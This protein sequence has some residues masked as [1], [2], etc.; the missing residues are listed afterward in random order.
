MEPASDREDVAAHA[1]AASREGLLAHTL[2]HAETVL[3]SLADGVVVKDTHNKIVWANEAAAAIFGLQTKQML[4][5]CAADPIFDARHPDGTPVAPEALPSSRSLVTG[6]ATLGVILDLARP[7]GRRVWVEMSSKPLLQDGGSVYGA[8]TVVRDVTERMA[9]TEALRFHAALLDAVGQAVVATDAEGRITY[10]N[11]A[12]VDM[13]GWTA[14]EA[15][16][17]L[18]SSLGADPTSD[19]DVA[20]SDALHAGRSW[21]GELLVRD[22]DGRVFPAM[23]TSRPLLD[24]DGTVRG[25]IGVGIDVSEQHAMQDAI[26]HQAA[27]DS[28]TGLPNRAALD[29]RL[30]EALAR[31]AETGR[32]VGVLFIDLDFFKSINDAVGHRAGD[33]VLRHVARRL[34]AAVGGDHFVAR[35]GGDEFVAIVEEADGTVA[36]QVAERVTEAL[37]EPVTSGGRLHYVTSSIGV[38]LSPPSDPEELLALADA[39][40]HGAKSRGRDRV[41]SPDGRLLQETRERVD[42]AAKLREAIDSELLA[43]HYQ[44][45][46]E[47]ASGEVVGVEALCRWTDPELGPISPD[48]F[49]AVAESTGLVGALDRWVLRRAAMDAR[50]LVDRGLLGPQGKVAVNLSAHN[51]VEAGLEAL[52]HQ[53]VEEAGI[54][55]P[56][57]ALEITETGVMSDPELAAAVLGRL[58]EHGI[59]VHVDDFGTGYSSLS[60]LRRLPISV[61]K[62]D[63]TFIKDLATEPDDLAITVSII[64]LSR[65]LGIR[66]IAEGVETPQQLAL[67]KQRGCWAGQGYLWSPPLPL[68][69]LIELL[70]RPDR[71]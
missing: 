60:Y 30:N 2:A 39:A 58:R 48:R 5:A 22:R 17:R 29:E 12:A 27:H 23:V 34:A 14:E 37:R 66:T 63:R 68:P 9:R 3:S 8:V 70:E 57:L 16:G 67:L 28:L 11:R 62:I 19:A 53:A 33:A 71:P 49:I 64:E 36:H 1:G 40:M 65:A 44:P 46:V 43:L 13:Y 26:A 55:Y 4:G 42:L 54:P 52:A 20:I 7:N 32:P 50:V 15:L 10:W 21:T 47:L 51:V 61:I 24:P 59:G 41:G 45:I 38:A 56:A 69:A 6:T 18:V 35:F 31:S 25:L